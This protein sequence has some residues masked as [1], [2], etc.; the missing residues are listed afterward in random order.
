MPGVGSFSWA[1]QMPWYVFLVS[2]DDMAVNEILLYLIALT[3]LLNLKISMDNYPSKEN[4]YPSSLLLEGHNNGN[5]P[6]NSLLPFLLI[7]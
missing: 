1:L 3:K 4:H 6:S 2:E 5:F 7:L